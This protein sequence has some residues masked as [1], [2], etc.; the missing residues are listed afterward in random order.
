VRPAAAAFVQRFVGPL[1]RACFRPEVRGWERLP[2]DRPYLLVANHSAGVGLAEILCIASAWVNR[3]GTSRPLAGFAL[4]L[5]FAVWPLSAIHRQ[6]GTVPSTYAAAFAAIDRGVPLLVFPGG[7]HE[8]LKPVWQYDRV[9]F[10]GRLGFLRIAREKKLEIV[11][12]GIRN[13]AFTAPILVRSRVLAWLVAVPRLL[14][15][16]RWGLSLLGLVGAAACVALLPFSLAARVAVAWLWV[17]S[18]LSFLPIVPATLRLSIGSPLS[19]DDL[20]PEGQGEE[21]LSAALPRVEAAIERL[22]REA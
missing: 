7:D 11:P 14:G 16:K 6:L 13:G 8:S 17:G 20:F 15:V 21:V 5:G 19:P 4:P 9:D 18:P 2:A 12:L 22:V 3:F 1:V 10:G